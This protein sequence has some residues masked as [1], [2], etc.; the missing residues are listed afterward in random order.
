M[1][2]LCRPSWELK[3]EQLKF[4]VFF[5]LNLFQTP[6]LITHHD[7][8]SLYMVHHGSPLNMVY[9]AS[10]RSKRAS[11]TCTIISWRHCCGSAKY[12]YSRVWTKHLEFCLKGAWGSLLMYYSFQIKS[13]V[14]WWKASALWCAHTWFCLLNWNKTLLESIFLY[15]FPELVFTYMYFNLAAHILLKPDCI[16]FSTAASHVSQ[17]HYFISLSGFHISLCDHFHW[18]CLSYHAMPCFSALRTTGGPACRRVLGGDA[19]WLGT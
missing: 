1:K 14:F 5:K 16:S 9:Y 6:F 13:A 11:C 7:S 19:P 8:S 18:A 3:F 12:K 2:T 4:L 17:K 10:D 15:L